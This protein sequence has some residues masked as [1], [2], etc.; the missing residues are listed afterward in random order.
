MVFHNFGYRPFNKVFFLQQYSYVVLTMNFSKLR[1]V[2][3]N[4]VRKIL[5][6]NY[7]ISGVIDFTVEFRGQ[8]LVM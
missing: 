2:T 7:H 1:I 4:V 8:P 5:T 6:Y 3:L